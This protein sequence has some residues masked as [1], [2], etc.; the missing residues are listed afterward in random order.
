MIVDPLGQVIAE[1][2]DKEEFVSSRIDPEYVDAVRQDF[3]ALEDRV[4]NQRPIT[5]NHL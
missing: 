4:L 3:P 2:G 1:G 5:E